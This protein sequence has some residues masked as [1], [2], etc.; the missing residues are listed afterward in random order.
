[1]VRFWNADSRKPIGEPLQA[2]K[3]DS[4]VWSIA[5]SP[6]GKILASG[7]S[8]GTLRFSDPQT[9][10]QT[11]AP[12]AAHGGNVYSV[13]FNSTGT[14]LA[15]A[16]E[17]KTVQLWDAR[18]RKPLGAPLQGHS[19][20]VWSVAL[21]PKGNV[22]AS[23][24][25]KGVLIL[26]DVASRARRGEPVPG[27]VSRIAGL[28]FS[29]DGRTLAAAAFS[30]TLRFVDVESRQPLGNPVFAE[31]EHDS[32]NAVA[33]SPDGNTLAAGLNNPPGLFL[34]DASPDNWRA[35][36]GRRANRN[37]S[38]AEWKRFFGTQPYRR[39][40]AELPAGEGADLGPQ[41]DG[42]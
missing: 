13:A 2:H 40:F 35:R 24:D 19:D 39:T 3:T 5:S 1:M 42:N 11:G 38:L 17:D 36:A 14:I 12:I 26:W 7:G 22:L 25:N 6:D 18:N 20:S 16:G 33:Y 15:S 4:Y 30:G 31:G 29:P 34:L 23:G 8:D 10:T 27:F 21:D 32:V 9:R 37:L 41:S 28:A